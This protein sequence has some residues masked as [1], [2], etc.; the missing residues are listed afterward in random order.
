[1]KTDLEILKNL[2]NQRNIQFIIENKTV[3]H[4]AICSAPYISTNG[5]WTQDTVY[6]ANTVTEIILTIVENN[7]CD[8]ATTVFRFTE[9]GKLKGIDSYNWGDY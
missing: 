1:M 5:Y 9:S 8:D 2:F 4:S 7:N 6:P 3:E